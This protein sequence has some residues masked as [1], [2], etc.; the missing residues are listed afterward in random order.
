MVSDSFRFITKKELCS[1]LG[2][3][4]ATL[5]RAIAN[6]SFPKPYK[7]GRRAV[8]WRSDEVVYFLNGLTRVDDAYSRRGD[9]EGGAE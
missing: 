6:G 7:I 1:T 9:G 3:S 5:E 2:I 4:R 8:R